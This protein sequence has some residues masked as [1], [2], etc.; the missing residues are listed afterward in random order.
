[1]KREENKAKADSEQKANSPAGAGDGTEAHK[2]GEPESPPEDDAAMVEPL[3]G[4]GAA[5][6]AA[7]PGQEPV[8]EQTDGESAPAT[9][10]ASEAESET[11]KLTRELEA[12]KQLAAEN[13][14]RAAENYDKFV[15]FQAEVENYKKRMQKERLDEGKY[16]HLPVMRDLMGV[17]DNLGRA[18]EHARNESS[19]G[20][21]GIISGVEMVAKQLHDIFERH[22]MKRMKSVGEPFDPTMHEAMG[23]VESDDVPENRV[24]EEFEAGYFLHDRVVKPA[25]VMVSK[26]SSPAAP[27]EDAPKE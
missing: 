8:P 1:M 12:A 21:E 2:D 17:I 27:A 5:A 24:M 19:G 14:E 26:K 20:V 3:E 7:E 23:M 18:I 25:M 4:G 13:Y 9:G 11:E 22:G 10:E 6:D 16:A 15:R